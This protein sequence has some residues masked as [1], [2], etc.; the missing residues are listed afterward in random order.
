MYI[1]KVRFWCQ[2]VL[3]LV[4]DNSLSYYELLCKVVTKLN[5][6][7]DTTNDL[8]AN[9]EKMV[10]QILQEWLDSGKFNDI[11]YNAVDFGFSRVTGPMAYPKAKTDNV[12]IDSN[13]TAMLNEF[14]SLYDGFGTAF[15][16]ELIATDAV[17]GLPMYCYR[18]PS[19]ISQYGESYNLLTAA[20]DCDPTLILLS[21]IHGNERNSILGLY[22]FVKYILE[23]DETYY[24]D[25]FNLVIVPCCNPYGINHNTR[26]NEHD[27]NINRNFPAGWEDYIGTEPKGDEPLSEP[28]SAALAALVD[29]YKKNSGALVIDCHDFN[30]AAS[31]RK[32]IMWVTSEER[33]FRFTLSQ[34][35]VYIK[36]L[37]DAAGLPQIYNTESFVLLRHNT[38]ETP[39]LEN[40]NRSIGLQYSLCEVPRNMIGGVD[41]DETTFKIANIIIPNL[42]SV[43]TEY[44]FRIEIG[45]TIYNLF[46]IGS[47]LDDSFDVVASK[48][49][50]G[51]LLRVFVGTQARG[52]YNSL[53]KF[54]GQDHAGILT[55]EKTLS[56][57]EMCRVMWAMCSAGN[58][59]SYE[60]NIKGDG[61]LGEWH[62][63]EPAIEDGHNLL[64]QILNKPNA[65]VTFN[66]IINNIE[67]G[68]HIAIQCSD[69][70]YPLVREAFPAAVSSLLCF[71]DFEAVTTPGATHTWIKI[72][73]YTVSNTA[74][75]YIT[76]RM[77]NNSTG[78]LTNRVWNEIPLNA[79]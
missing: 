48:M 32:P 23:S 12:Y 54:H 66:D 63:I 65:E 46:T 17:D 62:R 76:S 39:T 58:I 56:G 64:S 45:D 4:Y 24:R 25:N 71:A 15:T 3:P 77:R 18:R 49:P 74:L 31:P 51:S 55:I 22:N 69:T 57:N 29:Q 60:C 47:S 38:G 67:P 7:I 61:T 1:N 2:K 30:F 73:V 53:P 11:I 20:A 36:K 33:E 75:M 70:N 35:A 21:G 27:V 9:L 43:L 42:I 13:K 40:Y 16:K 26:N 41:A 8:E 19:G 14:Y 79:V 78:A 37:Y 50:R 59:K 72:T 10:D 34:A 52:L 5:E 44:A 6:V 28:E 68:E